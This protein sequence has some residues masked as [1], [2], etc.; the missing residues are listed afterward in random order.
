MSSAVGLGGSAGVG[1]STAGSS[2]YRTK[3]PINISIPKRRWRRF[4]VIDGR[5]GD[6]EGSDDPNAFANPSLHAIRET[7]RP[8]VEP[9]KRATRLKVSVEQ[10]RTRTNLTYWLG[11]RLCRGDRRHRGGGGGCGHP[12][13]R[14]PERQHH[15]HYQPITLGVV[16]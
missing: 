6:G 13:V 4:V 2:T 9:S 14:R 8:P 3:C 11:L 10:R 1:G 16:T 15:N 12:A 5:C 7:H